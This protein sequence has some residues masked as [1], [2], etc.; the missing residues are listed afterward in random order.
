MSLSERSAADF[1][2]RFI[3]EGR[4]V[5]LRYEFIGSLGLGD[6]FF[7]CAVLGEGGEAQGAK[8]DAAESVT[9]ADAGGVAAVWIIGHR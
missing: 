8:E 4:I 6:D 2:L 1:A 7:G 9:T 5:V 3:A